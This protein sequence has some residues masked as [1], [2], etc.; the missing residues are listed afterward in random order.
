MRTHH[1]VATD[2]MLVDEVTPGGLAEQRGL[3]A[4]DRITDIRLPDQEQFHRMR[5]GQTVADATISLR[6]NDDRLVTWEFGQLPRRSQPVY[7]AQILSSITAA[8]ICLFLWAYYPFRRRD[9]EVFALLITIYP[10]LRI[11]EEI[12]RADEPSVLSANFRW[13]ISQTISA[14]LLLL[15][16]ALWR[17]VL[18]RP[19]GSVLPLL[20]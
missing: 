10:V 12:I 18:S 2:A 20:R 17:F 3:K 16:A 13:T 5:S 9:G 14:L 15:T 4:G 11:L 19:K 7:P 6:V 1:E 8:W